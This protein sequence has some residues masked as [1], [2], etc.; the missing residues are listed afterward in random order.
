MRPRR[1]LR[2]WLR[3]AAFATASVDFGGRRQRRSSSLLFFTFCLLLFLSPPP[4]PPSL[5]PRPPS[6]PPARGRAPRSNRPFN[7][8]SRPARPPSAAIGRRGLVNPAPPPR[9]PARPSIPALPELLPARAAAERARGP[10]LT[11]CSASPESSAP[12]LLVPA[13]RGAPGSRASSVARTRAR[14]AGSRRPQLGRGALSWVS[15][16]TQSSTPVF[17][18]RPPTPPGSE[19]LPADTENPGD[20]WPEHSWP[21]EM[22]LTAGSPSRRLCARGHFRPGAPPG[23]RHKERQGAGLLPAWHAP[24]SHPAF[25][26]L[27][28]GIETTGAGQWA[29]RK[30]GM[31]HLPTLR[32]PTQTPPSPPPAASPSAP[33]RA[34]LPPAACVLLRLQQ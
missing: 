2:S 6:L 3:W 12:R 11:S 4:A 1:A 26:N 13:D 7:G 28:C 18:R 27:L 10:G 34:E 15:N 17:L 25:A 21:L 31:P 32:T 29:Q 9:G 23:A 8:G 33:Q 16:G 19:Q 30:P 20:A 22:W 24:Y 14:A 5:P